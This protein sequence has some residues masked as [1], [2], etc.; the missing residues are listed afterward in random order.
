MMDDTAVFF[1]T[2]VNRFDRWLANKMLAEMYHPQINLALWN[3]EHFSPGDRTHGV[4]L[5]FNNRHALIQTALNPER[6]FGDLY[7]SGD[8][9]IT[10]GALLDLIRAVYRAVPVD[11]WPESKRRPFLSRLLN[12]T[13][14]NDEAR[15]QENIHHHYDIGND[16]YRLWLDDQMQYT[17]AYFADKDMTLAE[18]QAAK[19][20]LI[21]RK[22][23]LQPGQKILEAG[24]G[25]GGFARHMAKHYGVEVTAYNISTEQIKYAREKAAEA[26]LD[27][28][29]HYVE[30]DYRNVTGEFDAFVSV[31]ML[32]H[33]GPAQYERL[34]EVIDR[35]LKPGG[36]GLIHTIGRNN[37]A[38]MNPWIERK[39]FP[40]AHPPSLKEMM[41]IFEPSMFSV[42]DVENL[43][44]HY[45]ET[46]AH[47]LQNFENHVDEVKEMFDEEFVRT[48]RLYLAGSTC[49]FDIGRLQLF[50]VLF[51]RERNNDIPL[52]RKDIYTDEEPI[53][54]F[55]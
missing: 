49:T 44:L 11:G 28:R 34:G 54:A 15:A 5:K 27:D 50:Q 8:L 45:R 36:L 43:R 53:R 3:G 37:K 29:V 23:R 33:M 52:T 47:W 18:A 55:E 48:W 19:M 6:H 12:Y 2:S 10:R 7:V 22:L 9:E 30:D 51:T 13:T 46:T 31:G 20:D 21:C 26:G 14:V 35:C 42:L 17:C 39:I 1:S 38:T 32:E 41:A 24:C 4:T 25:W 40:G 16:F